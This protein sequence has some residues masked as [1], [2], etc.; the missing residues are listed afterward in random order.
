MSAMPPVTSRHVGAAIALTA[1]EVAAFFPGK[2]AGWL[3]ALLPSAAWADPTL[4][5]AES[6]RDLIADARP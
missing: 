4:T 1:A 2:L 5:T 3:R 6:W